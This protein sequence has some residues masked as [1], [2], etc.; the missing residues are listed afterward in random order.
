MKHLKKFNDSHEEVLALNSPY[1]W[2]PIPNKFKKADNMSNLLYYKEIGIG[3]AN[4]V[5]DF[6]TWCENS[7][8]DS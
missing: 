4:A 1:S 5:D 2:N 6:K 3:S 7:V 8:K